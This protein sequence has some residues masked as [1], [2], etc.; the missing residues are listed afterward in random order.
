L[1]TNE[2]FKPNP[3]NVRGADFNPREHCTT[4]EIEGSVSFSAKFQK[5]KKDMQAS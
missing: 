2:L 5:I 3:A 4:M 1:L